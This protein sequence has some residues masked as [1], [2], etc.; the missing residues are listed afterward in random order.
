M[1][2]FNSKSF[3]S[4]AI[5]NN[6][7]VAARFDNLGAKGKYTDKQVCDFISMIYKMRTARDKKFFVPVTN[8][9]LKD[10]RW[11]VELEMSI[12]NSIRFY[13]TYDDGD[14]EYKVT[15]LLVGIGPD[16]QYIYNADFPVKKE[17]LNLLYGVHARLVK[18]N[19]PFNIVK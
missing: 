4:S 15:T 17:V 13:V 14:M 9:I 7:V 1:T 19:I 2:K 16:G 5:I 18:E 8:V 11:C 3:K 6:K 10:S 12:D